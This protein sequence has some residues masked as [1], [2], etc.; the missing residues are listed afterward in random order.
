MISAKYGVELDY[1]NFEELG[2]KTLKV[3]REFNKKAGRTNAHD[4]LP[5]FMKYEPLTPH[6]VVWDFTGEELDALW[7]F[8]DNA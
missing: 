4:R 3:E 1:S 8:I 7:D 6:N 2:I 5:E